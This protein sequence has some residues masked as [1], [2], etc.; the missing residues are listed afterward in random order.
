MT[1]FHTEC[2]DVS[3][4]G[5][6]FVHRMVGTWTTQPITTAWFMAAKDTESSTTYA[7]ALARDGCWS[8]YVYGHG[9]QGTP[10]TSFLYSKYQC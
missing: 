5:S 2:Y 1:G 6:T 10:G 7:A 9:G 3:D 4:R 8:D